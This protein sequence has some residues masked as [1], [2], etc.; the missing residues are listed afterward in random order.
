MN[1]GNLIKIFSSSR[2]KSVKTLTDER[3]KLLPCGWACLTT[4]AQVSWLWF[5]CCNSTIRWDRHGWSGKLLGSVGWFPSPTAVVMVYV[6]FRSPLSSRWY[7]NW[8]CNMLHVSLEHFHHPFPFSDG[9]NGNSRA[10]DPSDSIDVH[11]HT[12]SKRKVQRRVNTCHTVMQIYYEKQTCRHAQ[13]HEDTHASTH[14]DRY[15]V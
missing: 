2:C 11:W 10:L 1:L 3:V 12:H 15:V 5:L 7:C 8:L 4:W 6:C 14:T 13:N 9:G